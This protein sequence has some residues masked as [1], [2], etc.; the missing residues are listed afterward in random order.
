MVFIISSCALRRQIQ[1]SQVAI[2]T[3]ERAFSPGETSTWAVDRAVESAMMSYDLE[4]GRFRMR[5]T[6]LAAI[7]VLIGIAAFGG[8]GADYANQVCTCLEEA[9]RDPSKR[10]VCN[11]KSTQLVGELMNDAS[12]IEAFTKGLLRC[13][14]ILGPG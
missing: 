11:K 10:R 6:W 9:K 12:E 5:M 1:W 8:K 7:L 14:D 13:K 4:I 2:L 3:H